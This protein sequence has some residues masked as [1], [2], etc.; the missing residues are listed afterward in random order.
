MSKLSRRETLTRGGQAVAAATVI[1]V[2]AKAA[3]ASEGED[4]KLLSLGRLFQERW[5]AM[6]ELVKEQD[7][8]MLN[9]TKAEEDRIDAL[10]TKGWD[11][12][13]K[14]E[15]QIA[16]IPAKAFAGIAIKLRVP[17]KNIS[18]KGPYDPYEL[19][20]KSALADAERL[21]GIVS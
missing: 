19:N 8:A 21:A 12:F 13:A 9:G 16:A 3:L 18:N 20:T 2:A 15:R 14:I 6:E 10:V 11:D 4:S 17:A 5:A 7:Q 1:P